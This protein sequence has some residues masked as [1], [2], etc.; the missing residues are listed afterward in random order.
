MTWWIVPS[1]VAPG[2]EFTV[3][4]YFVLFFFYGSMFLTMEF[5]TTNNIFVICWD[6]CDFFLA[7]S[8]SDLLKLL[9]QLSTSDETKLLSYGLYL[10]VTFQHTPTVIEGSFCRL[11]IV[12]CVMFNSLLFDCYASTFYRGWN[13][14]WVIYVNRFNTF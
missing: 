6:Y 5:P 3:A 11:L 13:W 7:F 2:I 14:F 10:M 1:V 12:S 9:M 8:F 4:T